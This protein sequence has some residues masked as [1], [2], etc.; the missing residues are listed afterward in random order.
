MTTSFTTGAASLSLP[1]IS[2]IGITGKRFFADVAI[3]TIQAKINIIGQGTDGDILGL[4]KYIYYSFNSNPGTLDNANA[5]NGNP[6]VGNYIRASGGVSYRITNGDL[7][8]EIFNFGNDY[9]TD[10]PYAT[11]AIVVNPTSTIYTTNPIG[12]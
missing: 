6:N 3:T 11:M 4:I 1:I 10:N 9:Y 7:Y 2:I 5:S 8:L 12:H